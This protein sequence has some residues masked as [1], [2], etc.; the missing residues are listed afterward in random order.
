MNVTAVISLHCVYSNGC[1]EPLGMT[2]GD[3]SDPVEQLLGT[4]TGP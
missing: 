3:I 2:G 4:N 1:E